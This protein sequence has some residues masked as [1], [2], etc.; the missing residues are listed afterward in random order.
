MIT[1]MRMEAFREPPRVLIQPRL[2]V[3]KGSCKLL[4]LPLDQAVETLQGIQLFLQA[5]DTSRD[6]RVNAPL[7]GCQSVGKLCDALDDAL[8]GMVL[9]RLVLVQTPPERG[10]AGHELTKRPRS[11]SNSPRSAASAPPP[12][13]RESRSAASSARASTS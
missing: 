6:K 11:S 8:V 10:E 7:G 2:D 3:D 9:G 5:K 4:A 13:A 12:S 1:A